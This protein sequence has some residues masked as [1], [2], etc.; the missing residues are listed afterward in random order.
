MQCDCQYQVVKRIID[1]VH[2][3]IVK[4]FCTDDAPVQF[5]V[6]YQSVSDPTDEDPENIAYP[7]M[8]PYRICFCPL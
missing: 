1:P 8:D 4:R 5:T 7:E 6:L 2:N 3:L